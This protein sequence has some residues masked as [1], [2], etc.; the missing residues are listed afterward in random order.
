MTYIEKK[1][2][3]KCL[4]LF[5]LLCIV[6]IIFWNKGIAQNVITYTL[7]SCYTEAPQY[8]LKVNGINV[9]IVNNVNGSTTIYNYAHFSFS[10]N[11]TLE[12]TSTQAIVSTRI[13]PLSLNINSLVNGNKLAFSLSNSK[14]L[15]IKIDNFPDLVIAADDVE[16][17]IP[18]S[19]G[20]RIY[21]VRS[22]RYDAD[23]SGNILAT[24]SIQNAI[25]DA[26]ANG[27]GIVYIPAGIYKCG[28]LVLRSNISLYLAG[29][30]V[31]IGSA[32]PADFKQFYYKG[33]VG[34]NG[35][36]FIYTQENASH[37]KI[38]GRGTIDGNGYF[39]R[40]VNHCVND[41]IVP[42]QCSDFTIDGIICKNSG[43]WSVIPT[44]SDHIVIR[45]TKHFNNNDT[46]Y[47][48]DA[49]DIQ[50]CQNVS[51]KHTIMI[52]EDDAFSTKTWTKYT[53]IAANWPG[54]PE[55]LDSV[56]V[57]DCLA[58]SRCA[59]FKVGFGSYQPQS[60][61]TIKNSTSYRSMRALAVNPAYGS[62][63]DN[64]NITFEN[65]AVEG[66]WPR[67][68]NESR[69]LEIYT[70]N[71]DAAYG[72]PI[73]N[74]KLRYI[75]IKTFGSTPS[76]LKGL[77][78]AHQ[79]NGVSIENITVPG[80]VGYATSLSEMNILDINNY[81]NNIIISPWD[82]LSSNIA[83]GK[84]AVASSFLD[85]KYT[86]NY[87]LDGNNI[88]KW[89]SVNS[90]SQ[91]LYV[92]LGR[93][94]YNIEKVSI[95]WADGYASSYQLQVS[96]DTTNW[97]TV[98][99]ITGNRY[100]LS[101]HQH[102][103]IAGRFIRI[104][105]QGR[106]NGYG[107]AISEF[108]VKSSLYPPG[109]LDLPNY[110]SYGRSNYPHRIAQFRA[111][112]LSNGNIVFI[113]NSLTE[114]GGDW[115]ARLGGNSN[116]KNRGIASDHTFGVKARLG[117]IIYHKPSFLF[118]EIGIND[119]VSSQYTAQGIADSISDIVQILHSETPL[120]KI[121]VQSILPTS[122]DSLVNKIRQTNQLLITKSD[123]EHFT[124]IDLY[125]AFSNEQGTMRSQ[126]TV[127]GT[128][129]NESGY[130][131][132]S[133]ILL[134][135]SLFS[136]TNNPN[137]NLALH[138]P[139]WA[140]ST[141]DN[142]ITYVASKAVDGN[143]NTNWWSNFDGYSQ[144]FYVDL[145]AKFY[146]NKI[147]VS[148][149]SN[150]GYA[151]SYNIQVSNNGQDWTTNKT[152]SNNYAR[153]NELDSID[154]V[155]RYVRM[156]GTGRA[157]T[158]GYTISEFEVYGDSSLGNNNSISSSSQLRM[159]QFANNS[160]KYELRLYPN[161]ANNELNVS[162]ISS[163]PNVVLNISDISGRQMLSK[164][165][166]NYPGNCQVNI[167]QLAKGLYILELSEGENRKVSKFFKK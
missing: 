109:D 100:L 145:G 55:I 129:L 25:N 142:D 143:A 80:K 93:K 131:V 47:E 127:D 28:T 59:T 26:N 150:G 144:N 123:N 57:D 97:L 77:D 20:N 116:I 61:I 88:S 95:K 113:G 140:S 70:K 154:A 90:V 156:F 141:L 18:A 78:S 84:R 38:Y 94:V 2:I 12:I 119:L 128:H 27:G 136:T 91:N 85:P 110:S 48:N 66:F 46:L 15:I 63:H 79:V 118:L 8:K 160:S 45:N 50:E 126:Y 1:K 103:S 112:P 49:V 122:N 67:A 7:P 16:T 135:L 155:C 23:S 107:Y 104:L 40:T 105:C 158:Q 34:M 108:E 121:Y 111:T 73:S 164:R 62:N 117:E 76:M 19:T 124:F 36:F 98:A 37:I 43:L 133:N 159:T 137:G 60:N 9:P 32:N 132:W 163:N 64:K 31:I 3:P 82:S 83:L 165:W 92:D 72:G 157:N 89:W 130:Q 4:M 54:N 42:L 35:T 152:I 53:D 96:D 74:V 120:T 65:I 44:R 147:I 10:G 101:E 71:R 30:A 29:G 153:I 146:V 11:V 125:S 102:L 114:L 148:W 52:S 24:S 22:S 162:Y 5:I 81:I 39:M 58:W 149:A 21:N 75:Y 14:Y 6:L 41:L 167:S 139:A 166:G 134:G 87:S 106:G 161:P 13:S 138:H 99:S 33:S 51:I 56:I 115:G 151:R 69:W 17:D 68:G 86:A